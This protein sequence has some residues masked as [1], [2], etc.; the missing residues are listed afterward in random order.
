MSVIRN[1]GN[2]NQLYFKL[3]ATNIKNGRQFY[4]PY[5]LT[6]MFSVAMYYIMAAMQYNKGLDNMRPSGILKGIMAFGIYVIM[7]FVFIFLFYTNSFIIKRRKKELGIYNI[8]GMEKR[9][10]ARV[11]ILETLFAAGVSVCGGLVCGIVFNKVIMMLLYRLVGFTSPIQFSI[12][13]EAVISTV[14]L[15]GLIYL[16]ILV[17]NLIQV[18]LSKPIELLHGSNA[19]E[20]EPKTKILMAIAGAGCLSAGYYIAI[21]TENPILAVELFFVAVVLVIVGTYFLFMAGSI[22]FLKALR[23]NKKF[24]Y[25]TR[26]FTAVSGMLYRMKQN[27]AGLANICILSTMVLVMISTTVCMYVGIDDQLKTRYPGEISISGRHIVGADHSELERAVEEVVRENGRTIISK[28]SYISLPLT[29]AFKDEDVMSIEAFTD[30]YSYMQ[31]L[32]LTFVTP[33]TFEAIYGE[34]IPELAQGEIVMAGKE[35]HAQQE[36][37]IF[38]NSYKIKE[39]VSI[40]PE[41]EESALIN[42]VYWIVVPDEKALE[43]VLASYA[44]QKEVTGQEY[45]YRL[46]LEIDGTA[47]ERIACDNALIARLEE[48]EEQ[49]DLT[50]CY[51][52]YSEYRELNREEFYAL[53]GGFLFLGLFLG[54]MFLMVTVLIIFYKQIS[55]GYDDRD[56]FAIMERVGMSSREVKAT[57]N[58]QVRMVFLLPIAM[59]ALHVTMAFPMIKRLLMLLNLVNNSLFAICLAVTVLAFGIIYLIVFLMTSKDYYKIVGNQ[60]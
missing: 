33:E 35:A 52:L 3:T 26:H 28:N 13:V 7:I 12:P 27:A 57:I 25:Q 21:T 59:A 19:G 1:G 15:F 54:V 40:I 23:K 31:M 60:V 11:L 4:L 45:G 49:Q 32:S 30:G 8:L 5:L 22:A 10:I 38:G 51:A 50:G 16:A 55:E 41:G 44:K 34:T 43:E 29:G 39:V 6:G 46:Y 48:L 42:M 20:K 56:R 14:R 36:V 9:H 58:S 2:M 17:Y 47:E 18:K 53:N 24:Y 37:Q